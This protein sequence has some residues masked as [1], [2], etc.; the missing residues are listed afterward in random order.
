MKAPSYRPPKV[1]P[2]AR[3]AP[4]LQVFSDDMFATQFAGRTLDRAAGRKYVDEVPSPQLLSR[5]V[6]DRARVKV[7]ARGGSRDGAQSL[8]AFLGRPPSQAAFLAAKG[9]TA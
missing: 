2:K 1:P 4:M 7:L 8:E 9:L 6:T 3:C 5:S